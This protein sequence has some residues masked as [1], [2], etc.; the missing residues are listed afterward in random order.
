MLTPTRLVV[1]SRGFTHQYKGPSI[2][3]FFCFVFWVFMSFCI[4]VLWFLKL[5]ST[6]SCEQ[7][8]S[9]GRGYAKGK[10]LGWGLRREG[11]QRGWGPGGGGAN[12]GEG[13]VTSG[14]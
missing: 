2:F 6:A 11:G 4:C 3:L 5:K 10:V 13:G 7:W 1:R 9:N 8:A 14:V 12:G